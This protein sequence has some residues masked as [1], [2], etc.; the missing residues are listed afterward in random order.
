MYELVNNVNILCI[1]DYYNIIDCNSCL[2]EPFSHDLTWISMA[3]TSFVE[4][5]AV[6]KVIKPFGPPTWRSMT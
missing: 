6:G 2:L 4:P 5:K 1:I 3:F